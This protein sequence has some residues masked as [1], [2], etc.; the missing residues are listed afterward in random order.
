MLELVVVLLLLGILAA[1]AVPRFFSLRGFQGDFYYDDVL[2]A[3]RYAQRLAVASGC[4]VEFRFNGSDYRLTQRASCET[5]AFSRAIAHPGS[6]AA[7]YEGRAPGGTAASATTN[8]MT[9]DALGR[10]LDGSGAAVNVTVV[11]GT[12][13]AVVAGE[14]GFA[15]DPSI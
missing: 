9:F 11:V 1:V 2:S 4:P 13:S 12:R 14:S 3:L 15:H 5:G 10:V 8:P 6:G 7:E